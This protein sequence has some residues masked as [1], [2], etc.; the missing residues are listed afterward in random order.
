[1]LFH[2]M[3]LSIAPLLF[4]LGN[5]PALEDYLVHEPRS[6]T[7]IPLREHCD[8]DAPEQGD[9]IPTHW[10]SGLWSSLALA[11]RRALW[12]WSPAPA[13]LARQVHLPF[14]PVQHFSSNVPN[15][16]Q[17]R[18]PATTYNQL[19]HMESPITGLSLHDCYQSFYTVGGFLKLGTRQARGTALERVR[20]YGNTI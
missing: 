14:Q 13:S 2:S 6:I 11:Q 18:H 1:M 15:H 12:R 10:P 5:A 8:T 20:F 9:K 17:T 19:H 16:T 4:R 7:S 3:I